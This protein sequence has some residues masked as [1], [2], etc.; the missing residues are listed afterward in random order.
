M[1]RTITI[2]EE[3]DFILDKIDNGEQLSH[4]ERILYLQQVHGLKDPVALN[5]ALKN[6]EIDNDFQPNKANVRYEV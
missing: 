4:E 5:F 3:I 6:C 1:E 2:E